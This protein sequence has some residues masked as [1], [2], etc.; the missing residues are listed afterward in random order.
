MIQ[1]LTLIAVTLIAE[2]FFYSLVRP[3]CAMR[4]ELLLVHDS[5]IPAQGAEEVL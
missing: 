2:G 1:D 5:V 4:N 3:C